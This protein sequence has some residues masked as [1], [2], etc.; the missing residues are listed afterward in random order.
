MKSGAFFASQPT[1]KCYMAPDTRANRYFDGKL[2]IWRNR[3]GGTLVT[4]SI[5]VTKEVY[6]KLIT[7]EKVLPAIQ[8]KWPQCHRDMTMMLQQG[9]AKPH[10]IHN[11]AELLQHMS[12]MAVKV[13]LFDQPPISPDLNVLDLGYFGA[14]QALQQRQ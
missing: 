5:S 4:K 14:I 3:P 6:K 13:N 11:D 12:A 10:G 8:E 7:M 9:N 1:V 2:G